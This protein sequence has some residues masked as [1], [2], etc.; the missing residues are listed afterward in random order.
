MIAEL[1]LG[2]VKEEEGGGES[3]L[4]QTEGTFVGISLTFALSGRS[5]LLFILSLWRAFAMLYQANVRYSV[6]QLTIG[7]WRICGI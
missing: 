3:T 5:Y 4:C 6:K 1:K 7:S 2:F